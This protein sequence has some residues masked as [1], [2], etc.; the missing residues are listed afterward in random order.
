MVNMVNIK[1]RQSRF[2]ACCCTM[3]ALLCSN[4]TS[5]NCLH[6]CR[7]FTVLSHTWMPP[8]TN[9]GRKTSNICRKCSSLCSLAAV[10][11]GFLIKNASHVRSD[12]WERDETCH[13]RL[14]FFFFFLFPFRTVTCWH[15]TSQ[16]ITRG[17]A[18]TGRAA[19][20]ARCSRLRGCAPPRATP[21]SLSWA[22][23]WTTS[24]SRSPTVACRFSL[25]WVQLFPVWPA[26]TYLQRHVTRTRLT[27]GSDLAHSGISCR[28]KV[29]KGRREG[30]VF[31]P[32]QALSLF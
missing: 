2:Q 24:T 23:S 27:A 1:T 14:L 15:S 31:V 4:V 16:P 32:L 11:H 30:D 12:K 25:L 10:Q 29:E 19:W 13:N 5:Q 21:T 17:G 3:L 28:W 6:D 8:P 26:D 22:A 9:R 18:N 7:V 20:G